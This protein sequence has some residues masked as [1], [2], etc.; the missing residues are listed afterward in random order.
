MFTC[1]NRGSYLYVRINGP[2]SLKVILSAIQQAVDVCG[3]ENLSKSLFDLRAI[4]ESISTMDR[5]DM[6]VEV[7]K[8]IGSK[9]QVAAIAQSHL[10]NRMAEN[11]AVNRGAN[12]KAFSDIEKAKE[13]LGVEE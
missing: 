9:I 8:A 4:Q 10:I 2:F 12:L 3:H 5:Y 1:E 11:V 7:A 6:G 13:W